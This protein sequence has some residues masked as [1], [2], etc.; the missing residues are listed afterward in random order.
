MSRYYETKSLQWLFILAQYTCLKNPCRSCR[1]LRLPL[2]QPQFLGTIFLSLS[3]LK[4]PFTGPLTPQSEPSPHMLSVLSV[5]FTEH[6]FHVSLF[7]RNDQEIH[8]QEKENWKQTWGQRPQEHG[9][10]NE[11]NH[12]GQIHR[13]AA[14]PEGPVCH[15]DRRLSMKLGSSFLL[16]ETSWPPRWLWPDPRTSALAPDTYRA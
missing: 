11:P 1:V 9:Q 4:P 8:Q 13:I 12:H 16:F 14:E 5:M 2:R 3:L 6:L 10:T 7:S 15:Q